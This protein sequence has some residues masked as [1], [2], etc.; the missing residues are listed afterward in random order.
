M[1]TH[2]SGFCD[3]NDMA[4]ALN[5]LVGRGRRMAY[6]DIDTHHG[7][8]VQAAYYRTNKVLTISLHEH[9]KYLFPGTGFENEISAETG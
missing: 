6:V 4:V 2:A 7:D 9:G 1:L 8:D 5:Y 3:L